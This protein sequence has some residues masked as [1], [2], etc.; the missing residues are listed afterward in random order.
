MVQEKREC[1]ALNWN[2][3]TKKIQIR[4][5]NRNN[6]NWFKLLDPYQHVVVLQTFPNY[7]ALVYGTLYE[8]AKYD[9]ASIQTEA[10]DVFQE[11]K[12]CIQDSVAAGTDVD[13]LP[14]R[15]QPRSVWAL[16][17][18]LLTCGTSIDPWTW[19]RQQRSFQ[20][21]H[22]CSRRPCSCKFGSILIVN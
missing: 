5:S 10:Q 6:A 8:H 13:L 16:Q 4:R 18:R 3:V 15:V 14:S 17:Q 22:H 11:T 7:P 1:F 2:I 19:L 12:P 9:G 20:C 21:L